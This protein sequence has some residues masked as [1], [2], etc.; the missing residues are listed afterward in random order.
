MGTVIKE[1]IPDGI[2]DNHGNGYRESYENGAL[3]AQQ[4]RHFLQVQKG[5]NPE[6]KLPWKHY[7]NIP[8]E[9]R[10]PGFKP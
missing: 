7:S 4:S 10:F 8:K 2:Y 3:I 6:W 9:F 5:L 1:G